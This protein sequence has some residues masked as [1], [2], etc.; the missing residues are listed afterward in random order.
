MRPAFRL[1]GLVAIVGF[2]AWLLLG[3]GLQAIRAATPNV[4]T[5]NMPNLTNN[6]TA[7][8]K[9]VDMGNKTGVFNYLPGQNQ[10]LVAAG[11]TD[12]SGT[13]SVRHWWSPDQPVEITGGH[14][15]VYLVLDIMPEEM[16]PVLDKYK[17][18]AESRLH[19]TCEFR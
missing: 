17:Q 18:E 2:F 5:I 15:Q 6:P 1:L 12:G 9:V 8:F 16:G 7:N 4:P 13:C 11:Y 19:T 10:M 14:Y 3:G